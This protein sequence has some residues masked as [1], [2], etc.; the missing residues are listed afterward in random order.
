MWGRRKKNAERLPWYRAPGYKGNLTEAEKRQLDAF[1]MKEPHPAADFSDLP[2]EVQ[3]Y[4][5]RIEMAHYD[6]KQEGAAAK[7]L[8]LTVV[9]A[10]VLYVSYYGVPPAT[11]IWPYVAG[12]LLVIIPWFYYKVEWNRN[13]EEFLPTDGPSPTD[14]QIKYEWELAYIVHQKMREKHA[15]E[16]K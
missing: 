5:S 14:E 10:V 11:S 2:E 4:I 12:A 7:S 16:E 3:S 6:L 13:A 8:A 9:G 1:R 15:Q